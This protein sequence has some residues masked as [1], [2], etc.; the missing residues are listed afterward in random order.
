[1]PLAAVGVV[2]ASNAPLWLRCFTQEGEEPRRLTAVLHCALDVTD[3]R[4]AATTKVRQDKTDGRADA[5]LAE[6][7]WR[8]LFCV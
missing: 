7:G 2:S 8:C 5:L 6:A 4:L 1:M 3:E